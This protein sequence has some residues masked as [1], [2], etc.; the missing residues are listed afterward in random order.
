MVLM[1][2][3]AILFFAAIGIYMFLC[4]Y[5]AVFIIDIL[6]CIIWA[7]AIPFNLPCKASNGVITRFLH[8]KV[9]VK[10]SD[11][12]FLTNKRAGHSSKIF[13][14]YGL[15]IYKKEDGTAVN[16][17][18]VFLLKNSSDKTVELLE[19]CQSSFKASHLID[20]NV[21]FSTR[22]TKRILKGLLENGFDGKIC[23]FKQIYNDYSDELKEL[24]QRFPSEKIIILE[25]RKE[26]GS[27]RPDFDLGGRNYSDA[28]E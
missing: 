25:Y 17:M 11:I 5:I 9:Y 14:V 22:Y 27:I 4:D 3:F 16:E 18:S 2:I 20:E 15:G 13:E 12:I 8:K 28:R 24:L 23:V 26:D 10:E 21:M 7:I 6:F 1:L 19:K